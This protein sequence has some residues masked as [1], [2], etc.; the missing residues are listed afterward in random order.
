MKPLFFVFL[1]LFLS[2]AVNTEAAKKKKKTKKSSGPK[3]D[4][5]IIDPNTLK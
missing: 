4:S 2:L 1:A 3:D 5:K